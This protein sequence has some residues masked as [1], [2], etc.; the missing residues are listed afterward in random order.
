MSR[1]RLADITVDGMH[2]RMFT[3]AGKNGSPPFL[4]FSV[5]RVF[6]RTF[7]LPKS[8]SINIATPFLGNSNEDRSG[9]A[10]IFVD[11][12][13]IFVGRLAYPDGPSRP[14]ELLEN[15]EMAAPIIASAIRL[16][17]GDLANERYKLIQILCS[18]IA[19]STGAGSC[20]I[21]M[22]NAK[23]HIRLSPGSEEIWSDPCFH[24][25]TGFVDIRRMMRHLRQVRSGNKLE[26]YETIGC[27]SGQTSG[28]EQ[29]E[30]LST[31]ATGFGV[32]TDHLLG[33]LK[34][35]RLAYEREVSR[36]PTR[37]SGTMP[38]S[39]AF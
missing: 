18:L 28:H 31:V 16:A 23:P 13:T 21:L 6:F 20:R 10:D 17:V 19:S 39:V 36:P 33:R 24:P 27:A 5:R 14:A 12:T 7:F 22:M 38:D 15:D 34:D 1:F 4:E 35:L 32:E 25:S 26:S 30:M 9:P 3:P 29:I 11:Q 2:E 37:D 8:I